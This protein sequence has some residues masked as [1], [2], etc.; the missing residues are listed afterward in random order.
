[1]SGERFY[2]WMGTDA[3]QLRQTLEDING[4]RDK[5]IS[6]SINI[7][8]EIDAYTADLAEVKR[9]LAAT[10]TGETPDEPIE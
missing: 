2:D 3:D 4:N 5:L 9:R 7:Q 1:M 10:Q 8:R 6:R